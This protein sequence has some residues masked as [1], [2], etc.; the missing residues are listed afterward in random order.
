M[1]N[2][3]LGWMTQRLVNNTVSLSQ[4][5]QRSELLF[6]GISIHIEMQSNLLEPDRY[7]LGNAEGTTK[8]KIALCANRCAA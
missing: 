8:I 6:A 2:A 5:K 3:D 4:T 7:I 1:Q